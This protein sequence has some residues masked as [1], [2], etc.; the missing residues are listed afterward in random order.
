ML[1]AKGHAMT[2]TRAEINALRAEDGLPPTDSTQPLRDLFAD[3]GK[4]YG[5]FGQGQALPIFDR[6]DE[7]P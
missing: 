2:L 5:A 1:H 4:I 7:T 3:F 6:E